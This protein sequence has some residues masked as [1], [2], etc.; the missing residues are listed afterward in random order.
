MTHQWPPP[1]GC[2]Q[3]A[4]PLA[5]PGLHEGGHL[6]LVPGCPCGP[7]AIDVSRIFP[8]KLKDISD[9]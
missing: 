9:L 1:R 7:E 6:G 5:Q 4:A 3:R 8:K 2:A